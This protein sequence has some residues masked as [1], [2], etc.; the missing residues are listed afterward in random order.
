MKRE[1]LRIDPSSP[2]PIWSQI[3]EGLRRLLAQGALVAGDAVPS[4][5]DLARELRVNP[6]TVSK[7]YQR[8]TDE[9]VL[10]VRRGEGTFVV[11]VPPVLPRAERQK[12]LHE[13]AHRY[14]SL[15][16]TVGAPR[17]EAEEELR[18]AWANLQVRS[19]GDQR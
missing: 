7:A 16:L 13:G 10:E 1:I 2:E 17:D 19:K 11:Q 6:A 14:A 5:R 3:Q 18:S 8:L 15:G 4:V 9:G 12:A